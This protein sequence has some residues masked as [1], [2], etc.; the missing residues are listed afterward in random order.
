MNNYATIPEVI[1]EIKQGKM[2]I[3]VDNPDRENEGD[4]CIPADKA[5]PESILTMIKFGGGLICTAI[6]KQ[7]AVSLQL[8]LM[9]DP[10]ENN[11]KTKVNFTLSV[12]AKRGITTGVSAYD[13][14][15]TIK[16]LANPKSSPDDLSR[17]GHVFGLVA[18]NGGVLEREG[19]TEA[20][21]DLARLAG[22]TPAGVLC[23]IVGKDGKMAKIPE[24]FELS[25]KLNIKI[26][27]VKDM[28]RYIKKNPLG[29]LEDGKEVI[30]TAST[31]PLPT[32]HGNFQ[33]T[34]YKSVIDSREHVALVKGKI[35]DTVFL[36]IHSQCLTGDTFLSLR[37]DCGEQ[38]H[39]SMKLINKFGSGV[40]LYLSQEG[41]GIGLMNKIKAYALQD[42]GYDTVEANESLGL[43]ID[44][45]QYKVAVD[46]LK[47]LGVSKI[48]LLTNNPDKEKQLIKFGIKITKTTQ[49]EIKP[50]KINKSYLAIKKQKL[51]HRL[52]FV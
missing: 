36:R 17:P 42:K 52:R 21:V 48:H 28:I 3:V 14:L 46:I 39:Q 49:L 34:V 41:R 32:K 26:I 44:A 11:E 29:K 20:A 19:H 31:I 16:L 37:C 1:E 15:K 24:L 10:L 45:R 47:D 9:V 43:P 5:T 2:L 51:A 22:F 50:N 35:K 27:S 4:F 23:E 6:T 8:P 33:L 38:L 30:K 7:Q 25:E 12:N 40:I 18:K 13:R